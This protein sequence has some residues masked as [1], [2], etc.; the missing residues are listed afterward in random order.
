MQPPQATKPQSQK[1]KSFPQALTSCGKRSFM[2]SVA[3]YLRH[4]IKLKGKIV[5]YDERAIF[6]EGLNAIT[7]IVLIDAASTVPPIFNF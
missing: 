4:G 7:Q 5:G 6:L 2:K 3:V 1:L